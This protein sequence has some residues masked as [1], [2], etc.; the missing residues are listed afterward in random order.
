MGTGQV[1]WTRVKGVE[2]GGRLMTISHQR[3]TFDASVP[4]NVCVPSRPVTAEGEL[5]LQSDNLKLLVYTS[6]PASGGQ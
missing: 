3:P 6:H 2:N 5:C 4:A 1:S